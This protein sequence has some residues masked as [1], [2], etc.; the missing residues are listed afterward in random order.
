MDAWH[1]PSDMFGFIYKAEQS[2]SGIIGTL[3]LR[4]RPARVAVSGKEAAFVKL[5]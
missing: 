4:R 3:S 1:S 5:I 2:E